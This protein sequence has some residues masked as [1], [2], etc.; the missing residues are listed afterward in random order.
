LNPNDWV[1]AAPFR[2]M[3]H[4]LVADSGLAWQ[5]VAIGAH[6]PLRTMRSLLGAGGTGQRRP[7]RRIRSTDARRLMGVSATALKTLSAANSDAEVARLALLELPYR[8]SA[9]QLAR[10]ANT[11]M[12]TAAGLLT[13]WVER[14]PMGVVWRIQ[15]FAQEQHAA[16]A[17]DYFAYRSAHPDRALAGERQCLAEAA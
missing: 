12:D 4:R 15:A 11:D 1:D 13:G 17:S 5:A 3:A 16:M 6:I 2:A 10:I 7:L 9:L 14:C 8:P